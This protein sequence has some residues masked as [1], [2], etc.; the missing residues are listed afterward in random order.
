MSETHPT[1]DW[2]ETKP[3]K[4]EEGETYYF[5]SSNFQFFTQGVLLEDNEDTAIIG[6]RLE[7]SEFGYVENEIPK[8]DLIRRIDTE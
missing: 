6:F 5:W 3:D 2:H 4:I 8:E 7:N 1:D